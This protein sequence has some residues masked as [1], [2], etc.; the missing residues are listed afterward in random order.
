[1]DGT[2]PLRGSAHISIIQ[3]DYKTSPRIAYALPAVIGWHVSWCWD[4]ID[5]PPIDGDIRLARARWVRAPIFERFVLK[6]ALF[7]AFGNLYLGLIH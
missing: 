6:E 3:M 7:G 1:M 4:R 5:I 2:P